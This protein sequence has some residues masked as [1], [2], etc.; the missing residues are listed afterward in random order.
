LN[1][2]EKREVLPAE[3]RLLKELWASLKGAPKSLSTA[4]LSDLLMISG[5]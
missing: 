4:P 2:A 1:F 3:H 5:K